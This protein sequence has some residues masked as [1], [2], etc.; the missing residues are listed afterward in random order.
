[1]NAEGGVA[2][3]AGLDSKEPSASGSISNT[4]CIE[5]NSGPARTT[6]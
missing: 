2:N 5:T 1:M 4:F 3:L 6:S